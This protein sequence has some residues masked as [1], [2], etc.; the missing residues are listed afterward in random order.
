MSF[1]PALPGDLAARGL[2]PGDLDAVIVTGDA[3]VD[4]ASF[5]AALI[6]RVL[7]AAGYKVGI[8]A[9]PDPDDSAAFRLLGRPRLAF[10][11]TAGAIDSMVSS[12]TAN[13]KPRA[14][15]DYAP[16]GRPG[17]CL[18]GD[19]SIGPG[20]L[21]R[22]CARPD[23][24]LIAY[25]TKCREAYK[26]VA[27]IVGGIE[28]SLRR[29]SH[30][31]Y[32]SDS[33][34]RSV[35]LDSKADL[36]VYGMGETA[37]LEIMR[38]LSAGEEASSIRGVR[39]TVWWSSSKPRWTDRSSIDLPAYEKIAAGNS[40][41][42]GDGAAGK[43]AFADS[44]RLQYRN[45]DPHSANLLVQET[46]GRWVVQEPP[47]FPLRADE[48]DRVYELPYERDWHPMYAPYGGVPALAEVKFSLV[49]SRGCFG[50]CSFCSL[51]FHQGRE[52]SARSHASILREAR[53][54]TRHPDFKGF[55]HDVGGP[56]A[57]FRRNACEKMA[58]TG[59][60]V[61]RRCLA[62]TPCPALEPDHR[63][64]LGL[65]RQLR[66]LA[67]V[68][69]VFVRSGL[70]FDY[71]MIDGDQEF[72]RELVQHHVSGQLKVA[73]EHVS[74]KVLELMGKPPREIY[75][76]FAQR[77]ASLNLQL[78][79]RQYLVPYF[80]SAHPGAGIIDAIE[81]AEHLRDT[82]FTPDHVQDFY[83]TPGILSTAMYWTG[84][85][86]IT[87]K[88]IH[89]ARGAR[90]RA[91]QRALLQYRKPENH[92]LVREALLRAGRRDLIGS[93]KK[94]LIP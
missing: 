17:L 90:E 51:T 9:R 74:R 50:A 58:R 61:D 81:L 59:A 85:D 83:P 63:D 8:I 70:R 92:D 40:D 25:A 89:V 26:G 45:T 35:L 57:N 75:D 86:P 6:G 78:G 46:S 34:R 68:K 11:V 30:Y 47:A 21:H 52:V 80:I 93:G 37:I 5:G 18:R 79:L 15:D 55:I 3:Y 54:L 76:A 42:S 39:G 91:M 2:E 88:R 72:L 22:V 23:R 94:C 66:R 69:K 56:T 32:W 13:K 82:G 44:F 16:G 14:E 24:A 10:L 71:L 20:R 73:P 33:P 27:I 77:Y 1:L 84:L 65:L 60:C 49:S 12:Y 38:R 28:A 36:L 48:L 64:Y 7:E 67:G 53:S 87:G 43:A 29:L 4:H 31:D 62:P 19:G 41:Q